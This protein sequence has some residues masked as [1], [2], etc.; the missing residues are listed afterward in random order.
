M[1]EEIKDKAVEAVKNIDTEA[2]KAKAVEIKDKAV[3]AV[4]SIDTEE[5]KAKAKDTVDYVKALDVG[6]MVSEG[7]NLA[8]K[9][10]LD[11]VK[12]KIVNARPI[13]N[14]A[15]DGLMSLLRTGKDFLLNYPRYYIEGVVGAIQ[16]RFGKE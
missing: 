10:D 11:S 7:K 2:I 15:A 14:G 6:N 1:L 12:S 8:A 4:K 5:I 9:I 13:D 3:D 16:D